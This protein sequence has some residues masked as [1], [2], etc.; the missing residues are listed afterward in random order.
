MNKR[1]NLIIGKNSSIVRSILHLLP[2][3]FELISHSDIKET[4]FD[5]FEEIFLF[6]WSNS[7]SKM[8]EILAFV[9]VKKLVFISSL[10]VYANF[11]FFQISSYPRKKLKIENYI[12]KNGGKIMRLG[13]FDKNILEK[14]STP[15][16]VTSKDDLLRALSCEDRMRVEEIYHLEMG[17][18]SID[19]TKDN[20]RYYL[21]SIFPLRIV[22]DIL[23]IVFKNPL[24]NYSRELV[25]CFSSEVQ[26]GQGALGGYF[27]KKSGGNPLVISA[28]GKNQILNSNG[29]KQTV[30]PGDKMGLGKLWHGVWIDRNTKKVPI[31]V[32][33]Y[34]P[35]PFTVASTVRNICLKSK[36]IEVAKKEYPENR[37]YFPFQRVTLAMGCIQNIQILR[38]CVGFTEPVRVNDHEIGFL[39][40]I[41]LSEGSEQGLVKKVL[42]IFI[43]RGKVVRYPDALID[44]RPSA[45]LGENI[46]NDFKLLN[47]S[48]WGIVWNLL[49]GMSAY[50]INQAFF[51]KYGI[52]FSTSR[53]LVHGQIV[54]RECVTISD[55]KISRVRLTKILSSM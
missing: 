46:Q 32:P 50:K 15:V 31:I 30:L 17:R 28:D 12:L 10:A 21:L 9:P 54:A 20:V 44:V 48:Y 35:K 52:G 26:L 38:Q 47:R 3:N 36:K 49:K 33:R 2:D 42:G 27:L 41:S 6:S 24:R 23:M 11:I 25:Y 34:R 4:N 8:H 55:D 19:L 1:K 14:V 16:P 43:L 40:Y 51:N 29:F 37:F 53:L 7:T 13:F 45:K 39:G 22:F 18:G 5:K